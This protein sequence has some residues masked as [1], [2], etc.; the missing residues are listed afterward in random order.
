MYSRDSLIKAAYHFTDNYYVYLDAD[1]QYYY[2]ELNPKEN[3]LLDIVEDDFINELLAQSVRET[4]Y[5][6]TA[7][8][9]ELILGRA[10]ASTILEGNEPNEE[11]TPKGEKIDEKGIFEDWFNDETR[12]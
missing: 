4:I 7:N 10:F 8:I 2:V 3:S 6:K 1:M 5:K 11:I 9:R 12:S